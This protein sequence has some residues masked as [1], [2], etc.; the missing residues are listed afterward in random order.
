M[1]TKPQ[2]AML[3]Q[4]MRDGATPSRQQWKT[5][6]ILESLALLESGDYGRMYATKLGLEVLRDFR[7]TRWANYGCMAYLEDLREVENALKD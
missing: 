5:A 1:I 7:A 2:L 3:T 4:A 6:K